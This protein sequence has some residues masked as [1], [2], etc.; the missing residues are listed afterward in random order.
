MS[1]L[2]LIEEGVSSGRTQA[3]RT[4][5]DALKQTTEK[6][7]VATDIQDNNSLVQSLA[8]ARAAE[9][10]KQLTDQYNAYVASSRLAKATAT[11]VQKAQ[12]EAELLARGDNIGKTTADAQAKTAL[13]ATSPLLTRM[14]Q[15]ATA[16]ELSAPIDNSL[17]NKAQLARHEASI[18]E[19]MKAN[20]ALDKADAAATYDKVLSKA[21]LYAKGAA[22]TGGLVGGA[23][24]ANK[25]IGDLATPS[26]SIN[27]MTADLVSAKDKPDTGGPKIF[28]SPDS[29]AK[30]TPE[31]AVHQEAIA[32]HLNGIPDLPSLFAK[33]EKGT[34]NATQK[35]LTE[36]QHDPNSILAGLTVSDI[37]AVIK[38]PISGQ[39]VYTIRPEAAKRLGLN[40]LTGFNL[41]GDTPTEAISP[42]LVN[43]IAIPKVGKGT[44]ME[45]TK[46][47]INLTSKSLDA[48]VAAYMNTPTMLAKQN[49][50]KVAESL[51]YSGD[52]AG[53]KELRALTKEIEADR[54]HADKITAEAI[55]N[56]AGLNSLKVDLA[57]TTKAEEL[58]AKANS[59]AAPA[60]RVT[61]NVAR[62]TGL[63]YDT[64]YSLANHAANPIAKAA[65]NAFEQDIKMSNGRLSSLAIPRGA[66]YMY[67]NIAAWKN[68]EAAKV[69]QDPAGVAYIQQQLGIIKEEYSK[70]TEGAVLANMRPKDLAVTE[71]YNM[72]ANYVDGASRRLILGA[73]LKAVPPNYKS[74]MLD[75]T[76]VDAQLKAQGLT[77]D[78]ARA[79]LKTI[80]AN[81][82]PNGIAKSM[83]ITA[84]VLQANTK[85]QMAKLFPESSMDTIRNLSNSIGDIPGT[86]GR[87][88]MDVTSAIGGAYNPPTGMGDTPN[89]NNLA[90]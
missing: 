70:A 77:R 68:Q 75:P 61:D 23:V 34:A 60:V 73:M 69:S 4:L 63:P 16:A 5:L 18:Q 83:G 35:A 65:V 49:R 47:L 24:V 67:L 48:G 28:A 59:E 37:Q 21:K 14:H 29:T 40:P 50:L 43:P 11:E 20:Q 78:E 88:I 22:V 30:P 86:I 13:D 44:A 76:T 55:N 17:L 3:Q 46:A 64:V 31:E 2:K 36:K 6:K 66:T 9:A 25:V 54:I 90:K 42:S 41:P 8:T 87:G 19:Q 85:L 53:K 52:A 74:L 89:N 38:S 45:Q 80:W 57:A 12:T 79:Q 33:P 1:I 56:N 71:P 72:Q 26:G 10:E 81:L 27:P 84:D 58:A 51:A 82:E 39:T 7:A 62:V 15:N 32:K